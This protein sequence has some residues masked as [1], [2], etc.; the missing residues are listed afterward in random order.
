MPAMTQQ[1]AE[2]FLDRK[3]IATMVTL[4]RDGSPHC[5]PMWYTYKDGKFYCRTFRRSVKVAHLRRDPRIS[6]CICTH[7]EPYKF[8][9]VDG[10]CEIVESE[11]KSKW[12][13][14]SVRYLGKERGEAFTKNNAR[15]TE[16]VLLVISPKKMLTD[17]RA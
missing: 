4:R 1:E 5:V 16:S 7:D 10:T 17:N 15:K 3:L 2:E 6:L 9:V 12:P 11:D 13:L 14:N 8:V